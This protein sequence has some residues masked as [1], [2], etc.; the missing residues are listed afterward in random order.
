MIETVREE[1]EG[2]LNKMKEEFE[3]Q[4]VETRN[5]NVEI[6]DTMRNALTRRIDELD[7][8]FDSQFQNYVNET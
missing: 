8:N 1:E 6:M 7:T 5:T 3:S 4:T 2:K